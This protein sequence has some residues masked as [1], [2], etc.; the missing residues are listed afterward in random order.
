M[1][2][3][4]I[5]LLIIALVTLLW[6]LQ[7]NEVEEERTALIK[8]VL[9]LEQ[10][11]R[12][13][14]NGSEDQLQQLA[15]DLV[16]QHD[17]MRTFRLRAAHML[18]NTPEISQ[19]L[20]LDPAHRVIEALPSA[21]LPDQEIEA[22]GLAYTRQAFDRAKQL[23]KPAYSDP[24][25]SDGKRAFV[26]LMIPVFDGRRLKGMLAAVF[27][28][29]TLLDSQVPWWFTQKYKVVIV[30]DNDTQYA[31]KTSVEGNSAQSYEIPFDPPGRGLKLRVTSYQSGENVLPRILST[32]IIL[33]AGGVFWSL[34]LVRD[35]MRKRRAPKRPCVANTPSGPPW[36]IP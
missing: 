21:A 11:L 22:F 13:H 19:I 24:F 36:K 33:L 5:V 6:L 28:L 32:A 16:Q 18:K 29:E 17:P 25:F 7:R 4:G 1:P 15:V 26:E 8:D 2:K 31:A 14:L 23:G 3:F 10:N 27:P 9:W 30:D 35:L 20:W 34:W 12:F